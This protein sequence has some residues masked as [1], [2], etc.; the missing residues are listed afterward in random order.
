MI[1]VHARVSCTTAQEVMPWGEEDDIHPPT[2]RH[3]NLSFSMSVQTSYCPEGQGSRVTNLLGKVS[4]AVS[5]DKVA[6]RCCARQV[7]NAEHLSGSGKAVRAVPSRSH[8]RAAGEYLRCWDMLCRVR[9]S[10]G[11]MPHHQCTPLQSKGST[12]QLKFFTR[13]QP[14]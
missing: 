2:L 6:A 5:L 9:R 10:W 7:G 4:S 11:Y 1:R 3:R 8:R 12:M 13:L 14:L